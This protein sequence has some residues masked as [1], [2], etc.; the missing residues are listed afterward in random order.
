MKAVKL[1]P[2]SKYHNEKHVGCVKKYTKTAGI[3]SDE[4]QAPLDEPD[5]WA[6]DWVHQWNT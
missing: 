4:C 1:S 6:R 5:G 2:L 3:L